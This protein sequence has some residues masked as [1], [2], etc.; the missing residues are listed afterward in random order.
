M[1]LCRVNAY[2]LLMLEDYE[3]LSM[4]KNEYDFN[5]EISF[6]P[7]LDSKSLILFDICARTPCNQL[8]NSE[9]IITSEKIVIKG[10][11]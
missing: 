8:A 4:D 7:C 1:L 9:M 3:L 5:R 6:L 2:Y 11:F 10:Y